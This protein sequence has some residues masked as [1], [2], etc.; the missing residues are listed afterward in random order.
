MF[1]WQAQTIQKSPKLVLAGIGVTTLVLIA[2]FLVQ[3]TPEVPDPLGAFLPAGSEL[4]EAIDAVRESFPGSANIRIV[5]LLAKGD[6]LGAEAFQEMRGLQA[7]IVDDPE[8]AP[9]LADQ[10]LAGYVQIIEPLLLAQSLDPATVSDTDIGAAADQ[11]A[12]LPELA[13]AN[14]L[15]NRF[16][17][18][19]A[20]GVPLAGLSLVTLKDTGDAVGLRDA[21]LRIHA[22]ANSANLAH[23]AV[24]AV[25][26]AGNDEEIA[27][28]NTVSTPLLTFIALAVIALLLTVFYRTQS[29]VHITMLG[30]GVTLAWT[31][32]AQAWLSPG[33]AGILDPDNIFVPIVLVL[34]ISLSVDYALQITSR[35]RE[36]L[37]LEGPEPAEGAPAR[38]IGHAVRAAGVP[39]VLAAVTTAVS[40]L[41]N[42]TSRFE[43]V[44][45]FGILAAIGVVSGWIVMTSFVPA[46]RLLLDRKRA[47]KGRELAT[48]PVADTVPGTGAILSRTAAAIVRRPLAVLGGAIAVT[49]VA[50]IAATSVDTTTT[51]T[52][53]LPRGSDA[54]E[55]ITFIE[56]N[57][58]AGASTITV[59]VEADLDTAASVRHL[60]D[61]SA[62]LAAPGTRPE[63]VAG[64]PTASAVTLLG[65]WATESEQPGDK[66]DPTVSAAFADLSPLSA[67][68][69]E[70]VRRAWT[71]LSEID[72][73]GFAAVVDQRSGGPDRTILQI[74]VA[75][76]SATL[77]PQL[78][79]ELDDLWGGDA[80]QTT[81]TG[82]DTLAALINSELGR[83]QTVTIPLTIAAAMVILMLYFG[84]SERRPTLGLISVLPIAMVV[85]W[86]L[87]A[88]W[89]LRISYNVATALVVALTIG[90][91]VDYTIHLTHRFIEA[92]KESRDPARALRQ[93]MTT[94]GGALVASALTTA[95][96]L[97]VLLFSPLRPIQELGA[98]TSATILLTLVATFAVLPP[99]LVL[100]SRYH[101]W[102]GHETG[103]DGLPATA[104]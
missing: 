23:L 45:D 69:D 88:M 30:L 55:S 82:G 33:G 56:D 94:T 11:V 51:P 18:R 96:G 24:T 7:G 40:L 89:I 84:F 49:I 81:A 4:A 59:L 86:L 32:G 36:A 31:L 2:G 74:P 63:G 104:T 8:V 14:E 93:A 25:S 103:R 46:A 1:K 44:A 98:L 75:A 39:V 92:E 60:F 97:L 65:D 53:F 73:V 102:R 34:L 47:A 83:S 10:P 21:Q 54:L 78:L 91:G 61:F 58:G 35:Y 5:Q 15:L 9:F 77:L 62:T 41:M 72:P 48:K 87:A 28:V 43:P 29:D 20:A 50:V 27:D 37:V 66:F 101:R 3:R 79:D 57:F 26:Q 6:V 12:R 71:L 22:I 80:S 42:L 19:D 85:A 38:S 76:D 100:W 52:D 99:L 70:Q 90:I 68:S 67:A 64:P 16:V 95:L 17:P 13:T